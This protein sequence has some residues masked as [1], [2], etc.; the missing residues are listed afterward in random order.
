MKKIK[1]ILRLLALA[2]LMMLAG[3]GVGMSGGV[4]IPFSKRME[5]EEDTI[6][7]IDNHEEETVS[8]ENQIKQ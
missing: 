5:S 3:I 6:E 2:C 8:Y 7:L 1:K 4:P